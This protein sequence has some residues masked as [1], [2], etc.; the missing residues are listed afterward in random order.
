MQKLRSVSADSS[1]DEHS[2]DY[3]VYMC[4]YTRYMSKNDDNS[5]ANSKLGS[6]CGTCLGVASWT[7]LIV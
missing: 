7:C 6:S 5:N 4:T 1:T 3:G 2:L